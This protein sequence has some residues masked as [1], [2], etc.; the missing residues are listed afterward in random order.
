[1]R[2]LYKGVDKILCLL[3]EARRKVVFGIPVSTSIE[4]PEVDIITNRNQLMVLID[5]RGRDIDK[6][7][8]KASRNQLYVYD[9]GTKNVIKIIQLPKEV[10]PES[11]KYEKYFGT[12]IIS[13][14]VKNG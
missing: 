1:M 14:R 3:I 10:E 11:L 9:I 2:K 8:V 6:I 12:C 4:D 5:L 7:T 13:L